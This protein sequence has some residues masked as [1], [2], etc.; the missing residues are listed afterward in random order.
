MKKIHVVLPAYNESESLPNLLTR[1]SELAEDQRSNLLIHVV[2]DGSVDGTGE[3]AAR[4]YPGLTV[5]VLDHPRNMGLGQAVQTGIRT[6][7]KI[8]SDEEYMVLMDADD[9]HD[10]KLIKSLVAALE[11]GADIA[12]ASRFVPGGDDSTAPFFRRLL[13][14]GAAL[15]FRAALPISGNIR[16]FTSGFRAYRVSIIKRADDHWGERLIE[17]RGFA[18][19]VELLMKL[20]YCSPTVVEVPMYLEYDRKQGTSKIRITRTIF[21]YLKLAIRDRLSPPPYREL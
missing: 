1:F 12:I 6:V 16:D 10:P 9:T 4:P 20:R 21:Q 3:V 11:A 14:R 2:N 15:C 18:C 19:M 13:S 8:A 5:D 7:A 17:E